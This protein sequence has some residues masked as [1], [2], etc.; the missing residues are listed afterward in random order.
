MNDAKISLF[1]QNE[2]GYKNENDH[3]ND[4]DNEN[5]TCDCI[6][7]MEN[8]SEN[9]HG[10][11]CA[12][13]YESQ[14]AYEFELETTETTTATD[15]TTA[16]ATTATATTAT[17]AVKSK[18]KSLQSC[19]D[20]LR[21][22]VRKHFSSQRPHTGYDAQLSRTEKVESI[23]FGNANGNANGNTNAKNNNNHQSVSSV[24]SVSWVLGTLK[25]RGFVTIDT[26]LKTT[27]ESCH[28]LSTFLQKKTKQDSSI[29]SDTVAFLDA[30]DAHSCG[31]DE[32]FEL[33][34]GIANF[35]NENGNENENGSFEFEYTGYEPLPP[36]TKERPL[37][38]P[39]NIQAAQYGKGEFYVA[40]RYVYVSII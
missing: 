8:I 17:T 12:K 28:K 4:N 26:E 11:I 38:N 33:L 13:L 14:C 22:V 15:A 25:E 21:R 18:S 34:M 16:T 29:R 32:Q 5:E 10:M 39:R 9:D 7:Q 37:T 35:L 40:H 20:N 2:R 19:N 31:L 6:I 30:D 27:T 23:L 3:E 36:G 1:E 24:S